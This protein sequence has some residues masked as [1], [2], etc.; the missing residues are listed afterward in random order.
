MNKLEF[1]ELLCTGFPLIHVTRVTV[2]LEFEARSP[3]C[4]ST[5]SGLFFGKRRSILPLHKEHD[6]WSSPQGTRKP[7]RAIAS[8]AG[9]LEG[10]SCVGMAQSENGTFSFGD[11]VVH[12][13]V[14][15]NRPK[16]RVGV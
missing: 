10:L 16:G 1:V 12:G 9:S 5:R 15:M 14:T 13:V 6:G 3:C 7:A 11:H 2:R 4:R 8:M